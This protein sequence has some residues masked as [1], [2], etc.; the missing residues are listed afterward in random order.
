M[1]GQ[2]PGSPGPCTAA[3]TLTSCRSSPTRSKTL[4]ALMP[5]SS[6]TAAVPAPT[7]AAAGSWTCY[8]GRP[9]SRSDLSLRAVPISLPAFVCAELVFALLQGQNAPTG[10]VPGLVDRARSGEAARI[11]HLN[12][13]PHLA[14]WKKLANKA[15]GVDGAPAP[16][17]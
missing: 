13:D 7:S 14:W 6:L 11:L 12:E 1:T 3:G 2:S 9:D 17:P 8:S 4:A 16:P 15:R 5:P 10:R